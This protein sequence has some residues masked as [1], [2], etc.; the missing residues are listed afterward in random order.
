M[1]GFIRSSR[2]SIVCCSSWGC[3]F[4]GSE[5]TGQLKAR[6]GAPPKHECLHEHS[7]QS[8]EI[9]LLCRGFDKLLCGEQRD[10]KQADGKVVQGV[11]PQDNDDERICSSSA[12]GIF[13]ALHSPGD[14]TRS[15]SS[16]CFRTQE[17]LIKGSLPGSVLRQAQAQMI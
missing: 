2:I 16:L 14:K 13:G 8:L 6:S 4:P 17:K 7:R 12:S 9:F 15:A 5:L 10:N 1:Y 3:A 11:L